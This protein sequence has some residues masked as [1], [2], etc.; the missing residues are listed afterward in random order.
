MR[1]IAEVLFAHKITNSFKSPSEVLFPFTWK[2][3]LTHVDVPIFTRT[4]AQ[5]FLCLW[6]IGVISLKLWEG[7]FCVGCK[8]PSF[9]VKGSWSVRTFNKSFCYQ[10]TSHRIEW[11]V[12]RWRNNK[13]KSMKRS[14]WPIWRNTTNITLQLLAQGLK[15]EKLSGN[16]RGSVQTHRCSWISPLSISLRKFL[17]WKMF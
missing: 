15:P 9:D 8:T 16:N 6:I 17:F 3:I 10:L 7:R 1:Q 5:R 11:Q 14:P 2:L 12:M 4:R 13:P